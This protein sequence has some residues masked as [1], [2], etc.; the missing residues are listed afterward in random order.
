VTLLALGALSARQ[1]DEVE[2]EAASLPVAAAEVDVTWRGPE[3]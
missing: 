1:R 3:D 2:R